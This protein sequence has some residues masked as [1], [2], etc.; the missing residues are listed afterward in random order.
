MSYDGYDYCRYRPLEDCAL[1]TSNAI[2]LIDMETT[3]PTREWGEKFRYPQ[4]LLR[5]YVEAPLS[6]NL[7]RFRHRS[8]GRFVRLD[9]AEIL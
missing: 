1:Q 2:W 7:T 8:N 9:T 6:D 5:K 3:R 4:R